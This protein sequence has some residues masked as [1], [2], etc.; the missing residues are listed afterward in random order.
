[1]M[2]PSSP[3]SLPRALAVTL[4]LMAADAVVAQSPSRPT[5]V[6]LPSTYPDLSKCH[7]LGWDLGPSPDPYAP[8]K[9]WPVAGQRVYIKDV[10]NFCINLPDPHN[11]WLKK[12]FYDQGFVP[13]IVE[14]E[15]FVRSFCVGSY[16]PEGSLPM[17]VGGI[18]AA[19]V[20]HSTLNGHTYAQITGRMDCGV[21][22]INCIGSHPNAYDDGGQYDSVGYRNCGKEPYS[23]VDFPFPTSP[24]S[25]VK[26]NYT[27]YVEQAGDG[28]FCMRVCTGGTGDGEP[29]NAKLDTAGCYVTMGFV[30]EPGFSTDG[31]AVSVSLPP[32]SANTLGGPRGIQTTTTTL[33][34]TTGLSSALTTTAASVTVTSVGTDATGNKTVSTAT[35]G[36]GVGFGLPVGVAVVAVVLGVVAFL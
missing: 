8:P 25:P 12:A 26:I 27:Q 17:P 24:N 1:M 20:T 6:P 22:N 35:S 4:L 34:T 14:A 18:T 5:Y 29:C 10:Q 7:E 32:P 13:S 11:E 19:H 21:L 16:L 15:G 30:D 2:P 9:P 28:I 33:P 23:G 3:A 36:S 31:V